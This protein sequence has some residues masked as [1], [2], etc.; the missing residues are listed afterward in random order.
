MNV[1]HFDTES[2]MAFVLTYGFATVSSF[3]RYHKIIKF[4]AA[5]IEI[6]VQSQG[7]QIVIAS[8]ATNHPF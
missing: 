6:Y 2:L 1:G 4:T 7:L 3:W 5:R 8:H